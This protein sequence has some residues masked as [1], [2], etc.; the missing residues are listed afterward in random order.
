MSWTMWLS[1]NSLE[2]W[3]EPEPER[4]PPPWLEEARSVRSPEE[5]SNRSL[6]VFSDTLPDVIWFLDH[7]YETGREALLNLPWETKK[8]KLSW[9][10]LHK[11]P[12]W[13][14]VGLE[15]GQTLVQCFSCCPTIW[16]TYSRNHV[17]PFMSFPCEKKA[18]PISWCP[19]H[20]TPME[21]ICKYRETNA[22]LPVPVN[23]SL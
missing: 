2:L 7:F 6:Y 1:R 15:P 23:H 14:C 5:Y 19:G 4:Q 18:S 8:R 3:R 17:S 10:G 21:R 20:D 11:V 22:S 16:F 13:T 9:Y 12:W